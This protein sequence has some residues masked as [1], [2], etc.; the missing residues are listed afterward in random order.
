MAA[1]VAGMESDRRDALITAITNS[2]VPLSK[3]DGE[4]LT[5]PQEAFVV[6]I[7]HRKSVSFNR[8]CSSQRASLFANNASENVR[9]RT[10]VLL[11]GT[12]SACAGHSLGEL[13]HASMG[14]A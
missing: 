14:V 1:M 11:V 9:F 10:W 2:V 4:D 7:C 12:S 13:P 6:Q 8:Y 5:S 3:A